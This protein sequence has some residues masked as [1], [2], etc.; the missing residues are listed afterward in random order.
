MLSKIRRFYWLFALYLLTVSL[1]FG[2]WYCDYSHRSTLLGVAP[3]YLSNKTDA[4]VPLYSA[5]HLDNSSPI[6]FLPTQQSFRFYYAGG[7]GKWLYGVVDGVAVIEKTGKL[8]KTV[9]ILNYWVPIK[10]LYINLFIMLLLGAMLFL[11]KRLLDKPM[12]KLTPKVAESS[13]FKHQTPALESQKPNIELN[14]TTAERDRLALENE[15]LK[16]MLN[17]AAIESPDTKTLDAYE[18]GKLFESY[19]STL[20]TKRR[21]FT[22]VEWTPDKGFEESIYVEANANPDLIIRDEN[23]KLCALECKFRSWFH[24]AN[25]EERYISWANIAQAKRYQDFSVDRD[26]PV[27]VIIGFKGKSDAPKELYLA[28]INE[29]IADSLDCDEKYKIISESRIAK[30]KLSYN[31][32]KKLKSYLSVAEAA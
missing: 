15:Q 2:F 12:K 9:Q 23:K 18:K 5:E 21:Q 7:T 1:A 6:Y 30:Y 32:I 4:P 10:M 24:Q 16:K 29:L 19:I 13:T 20:I 11:V 3:I 22:I 17:K 27:L 26:M 31:L 28:E 14:Q 25:L 8:N